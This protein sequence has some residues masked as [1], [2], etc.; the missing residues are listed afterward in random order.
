MTSFFSRIIAN[1]KTGD[2][3]TKLLYLNLSFFIIYSI[4]WVPQVRE[5]QHSEIKI[6]QI[7][8]FV[9]HYLAFP[10]RTNILIQRPWTFLSYMFI[11]T[12]PFHILFN[13]ICLFFSFG[14]RIVQKNSHM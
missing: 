1:Y 9:N 14:D 8:Q 11:H 3:F 5:I 12:D 7:E 10:S 6:T 2:G 13:M 4:I